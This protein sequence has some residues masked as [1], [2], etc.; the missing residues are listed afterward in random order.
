MSLLRRHSACERTPAQRVAKDEEEQKQEQ[1]QEQEE[2]EG[3]EEGE[4]E[5]E[6]E[7]GGLQGAVG[8]EEKSWGGRD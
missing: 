5:E 1:E 7:E 6:E 2:E 4:G 8:H 3:E